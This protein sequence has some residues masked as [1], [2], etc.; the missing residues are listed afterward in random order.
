DVGLQV[1]DVFFHGDRD[2]TAAHRCPELE[3]TIA[4]V[5]HEIA[6]PFI[7]AVPPRHDPV[8]RTALAARKADGDA[9]HRARFHPDVEIGCRRHDADQ[10]H[11]AKASAA[12]VD[13]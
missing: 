9:D 4:T 5:G 12:E 1:R 8:D 10:F 13:V 6:R 11:R 2:V 7:G 3:A